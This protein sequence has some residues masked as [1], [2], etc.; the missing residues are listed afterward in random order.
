M[1]WMMVYGENEEKE[2][3]YYFGGKRNTE[4]TWWW[5][6]FTIDFSFFHYGIGI[7]LLGG[8]S[9]SRMANQTVCV[10]SIVFRLETIYLHLYS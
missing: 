7:S 3:H 10:H 6:M 4:N 1:G 8:S 2:N 9:A 5:I